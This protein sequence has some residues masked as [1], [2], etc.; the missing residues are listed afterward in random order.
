MRRYLVFTAAG[1]AML[2]GAT[3]A[4]ALSVAFPVIVKDFDTSLV[5]SG[6][7]FTAYQLTIV[8]VM[9]LAG[10]LAETIGRGRAYMMFLA[11]FAAGSIACAF[12][13]NIYVLIGARV[14][15]AAGNAGFLPCATDIV[16]N[17]FPNARQRAVGLFSSIIPLGE[18]VGPN[19]GAWLISAYNW[20][21]VFFFSSSLAALVLLCSWALLRGYRSPPRN[22]KTLFDFAGAGLFV[23]GLLC[24][25]MGLTLIGSARTPAAWLLVAFAFTLSAGVFYLF[26]RQE[27]RSPAP[28]I[29][30]Q[31][32]RG[33][34]FVAANIYNMQYG[35]C[36]FGVLTLVPLYASSVYG[37]SLSEIGLIIT[38]RY[39][40]MLVFSAIV[41]FYML[42]WG[43]RKPIIIGSVLIS[44][45]LFILA[46]EPPA[47]VIGAMV[48]SPA[49]FIGIS[50]FLCG[51][52]SGT[53]APT[54]NNACIDLMPDRIA[55]ST[56]IRGM[57]RT[58]GAAIGISITTLIVQEVGDAPRAFTIAFAIWG[59]IMALS[60][61]PALLLPA[62]PQKC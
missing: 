35:M 21:A 7:V 29:D 36:A 41:S 12:A 47:L 39:I 18:I 61:L 40:G 33:R 2:L 4:T 28:V 48:L 25:M 17:E 49:V 22:Q 5:V 50:Q 10:R 34:S 52:G 55:T 56:G 44:C 32:L 14:L 60:I 42:R 3:N 15:Q 23:A 27:K 51:C 8:A 31:L 43:Y 30:F 57:F 26:V 16:S 53:A 38:P 54:S 9:P 37:I 62:R 45:G 24:F 46:W 59:I 1:L 11:L 20:Q 6:W 19:V 58:T 13:P